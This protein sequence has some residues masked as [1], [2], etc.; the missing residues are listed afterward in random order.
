MAAVIEAWLVRHDREDSPRYLLGQSYGTV[1]AAEIVRL[2]PDL[3]FD[4]VLLFALVTETPDG[5]ISHALDLPAM[6]ATAWRHGRSGVAADTVEDIYAGAVAY[7]RTDYVSALMQGGALPQPDKEAVAAHLARLTGLDRELIL[8]S[9]LRVGRR[10]FMFNLLADEGLRT[11]RLDTRATARL[12]APAQR[13]PYDDPGLSYVPEGAAPQIDCPG[14]GC[15]AAVGEGSVVDAYYRE[16]LGFE[17]EEPYRALNLDV[18]QAWD[19]EGGMG[20]PA[21]TLAAA[22]AARPELRL[23]WAAGYYD[24]GTPAYAGRFALDQAHVPADRLTAAYFPA[25]H[26][27]FVG[28]ENHAALSAAVRAFVTAD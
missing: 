23:F 13:P 12:D 1:R 7:A 16:M 9:D 19:F 10:D 3:S 28:E 20:S 5:L 6:A 24:L 8:E 18:N 27:V 2:F 15:L 26:S 21:E 14:P 11:G 4:G 25:G 22:M 17:N